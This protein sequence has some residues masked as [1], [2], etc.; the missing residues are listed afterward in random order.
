MRYRVYDEE[1][2]KEHT[3]ENCI[4]PLEIGTTR[5]VIIKKDNIVETHH[6]KVLEQLPENK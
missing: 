3:L 2:K 6:F 1:S 5:R 4:T